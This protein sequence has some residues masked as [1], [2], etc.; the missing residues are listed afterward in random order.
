MWQHE[1]REYFIE[2]LYPALQVWV[3]V[4][5][6][7]Y[8]EAYLRFG[9]PDIPKDYVR[10]HIQNRK[11]IRVRELSHPYLRLCPV[12]HSVNSSGEYRLGTEG[13]EM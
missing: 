13:M 5:Y 1:E 3:H 2:R 12:T 8:R 4:N 10:D 9:M 7:R 6:R 11:V